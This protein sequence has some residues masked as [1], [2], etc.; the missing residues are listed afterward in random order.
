MTAT[1]ERPP[2]RLRSQVG[3]WGPI[4]ASAVLFVGLGAATAHGQALPLVALALVALALA[5]G[6]ARW[7]WSVYGLLLYLPVSG[8]PIVL[9]YPHTAPAVLL[10]DVLFVVPA[11]AGFVTTLIARRERVS[12]GRAPVVMFGVFALV[13]TGQ[14][15]NPSL[16]NLLVGLI[17]MKVWLLYVPLYFVG[18]QLIT[19]RE[20]LRLFLKVVSLAAIAPAVIGIV[21][22]VLIYGGSPGVVYALYGNAAA[23][24]TQDFAHMEY[25]GGGVS[26]RIPSTFAFVTQY[27]TFLA[28]MI[29]VT[30]AWWRGFLVGTRYARRGAA[31]WALMIAA[32]FLC[33]ARGAY[34]LV[35]LLVLLTL[36]IERGLARIA[37]MRLLAPI[38]I[39]LISAALFGAKGANVLSA[40]LTTA[41]VEFQNVFV[42]GF[43]AA[44]GIT[45]L[46]LGTGA[47]TNA[48]R[49]AFSSQ[50]Q[51][52]GI[53]GTWYESW[54]VKALLE[55]GIGG[56]LVVLVLVSTLVVGGLQAHRSLGDPRLRAVSAPIL[57]YLIWNA[58]YG[59][60]GQ[61]IDLDP[62]NVYFWLLAG[63]AARLATIDR[64]EVRD[65]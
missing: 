60:K 61:Y 4:A 37:S 58:I 36:L 28:A 3:T 19:D 55:L 17:G 21:E 26:L 50:D 14:A 24:A 32:A 1:F 56:L 38:G 18:Y 59:V 2:L 16:P 64:E 31:L 13:V 10:K 6:V 20:T 9:L 62:T 57:A 51:F 45:W 29:A 44:F 35:P 49:Y 53:G 27:Y 41:R 52:H 25:A 48:T 15:L 40:T 63:I 65:E 30:Y 5:V 11:Y 43:R 54:Y 22:A 33:G 34:F 42:D 8:I 7:R 12:F 47:D 46:G 23:A 39:F